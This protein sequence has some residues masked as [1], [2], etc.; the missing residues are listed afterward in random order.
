M[1]HKRI[2]IFGDPHCG[3]KVGLTHPDW[4]QKPVKSCPRHT[5]FA[6]IQAGMWREYKKGIKQLIPKPL[7]LLLLTGDLIDG[8]G[9]RSGG[10]ELLTTDRLEQCEMAEAAI[11]EIPF[12][13]VVGVYGTPYHT[14]NNEDFETQILKNLG[15]KIGGHEWIRLKGTN[16]TFD[17]KHDIGASSIPH[18]IATAPLRDQLWNDIWSKRG[19]QPDADV[20]VRG[21]THSYV[22]VRTSDGHVIVAPALQGYGSKFGS[23]KCSKTVDWGFLIYNITPHVNYVE[24]YIIKIP[25]H[26]P[27]VVLV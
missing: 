15:G 19:E 9:R 24:E 22:N 3:H 21:H 8:D 10:T 1:K 14:G 26:R 12:N 20:M 2:G 7:D 27:D 4:Q 17:L 16:I 5:K 18:G 23:R 25:E 11:R 6:N 13:R